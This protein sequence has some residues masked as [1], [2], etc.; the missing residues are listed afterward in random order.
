MGK[1]GIDIGTEWRGWQVLLVNSKWEG[2][3]LAASATSV[4]RKC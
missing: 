2:S 3:D 1:N 4:R